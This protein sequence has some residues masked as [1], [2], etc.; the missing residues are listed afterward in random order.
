[1]KYSVFTVSTPTYTPAEAVTKLKEFGYDGV[2]WR[3]IDQEP[4]ANTSNFWQGNLCTLPLTGLAESGAEYLKMTTDAGLEVSGVASYVRCDDPE[5][6]ELAIRGALAV[7]ANRLRIGVPGYDGQAP[8]KP[9]WDKAREE[10]KVIADL[11]KKYKVKA[12]IEL[13]HRTI[14]PSASAARLFLDG[15]DPEY[16]GAIHDA[17]N[18]VHEGYETHRM[19][20]EMLGPY[21]AHVH[22]K[23]ARWFPKGYVKDG[24]NTIEWLCDW[25]TIPKGII[26]FRALYTA[27][28]QVGYDGWIALEDFSTE[29]KLEERLKMNLLY[30]ST[31]EKET[32]EAIG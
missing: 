15:F 28:H 32:R 9:L 22:A 3:V 16:V 19:S 25:A 24:F 14:T 31:I 2:E 5:N 8:F 23:N 30:L 11:A 7:G 20:L 18:M 17:G 26:D 12:L 27:L 10:Y 29:N 6:A 13:H 21:L 4:K 1:M